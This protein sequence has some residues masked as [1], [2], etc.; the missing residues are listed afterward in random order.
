MAEAVGSLFRGPSPYRPRSSFGPV[1]A[2]AIATLVLIAG[3]YLLPLLFYALLDPSAYSAI[4][5]QVGPPKLCTNLSSVLALLQLVAVAGVI[6]IIA[7]MNGKNRNGA[8]AL[9]RPAGGLHAY[10]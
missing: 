4:A 6:T 7:I 9:I 5:G 10:F 3:Q 1:V 8:L 2:V